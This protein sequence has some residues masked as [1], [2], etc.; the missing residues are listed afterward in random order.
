MSDKQADL[1][2]KVHAAPGPV[3]EQVRRALLA[4]AREGVGVTVRAVVPRVT[5]RR[6]HI[7]DTLAAW[8]AGLLDLDHRWDRLDL[9]PAGAPPV[10]TGPAPATPPT[11]PTRTTATPDA[12]PPDGDVAGLLA[13]IN[14]ATTPSG[15]A[16]VGRRVAS[17]VAAGQ[18]DTAAARI[19]LDSCREQRQ[20]FSD[21]KKHEPPPEDP[22]RMALASV[23]AMQV[24]AAF[25]HLVNARRRALLAHVAAR[26]L[27][28]DLDELPPVDSGERPPPGIDGG[29]P[30]DTALARLGLDGAGEPTAGDDDAG[31]RYIE[32]I[33]L[34]DE[35]QRACRGEM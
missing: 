30:E 11:P 4:L 33:E 18:L 8:R 25:D 27:A 9:A 19:I 26:L 20:G 35:W 31:M 6:A 15:I 12:A 21:A 16:E 34:P 14:A 32:R 17:L 7:V 24:A 5:G 3:R 1:L 10:A 13:A 29:A 28:A 22:R 23:E 2:T